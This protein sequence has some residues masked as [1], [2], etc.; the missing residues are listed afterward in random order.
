MDDCISSIGDATGFLKLD[1]NSSHYLEEMAD[2][3]CN[4][5]PFAYHQELL[6]LF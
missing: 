5:S 6:R 4:R 3:D 1:A 2:E